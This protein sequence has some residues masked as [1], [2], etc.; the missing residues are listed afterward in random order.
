MGWRVEFDRN[1]TGT[2]LPAVARHDPDVCEQ[3][4]FLELSAYSVAAL[5]TPCPVSFQTLHQLL[6]ATDQIIGGFDQVVVTGD[7]LTVSNYIL[8]PGGPGL[9]YASS[10]TQVV[11]VSSTRYFRRWGPAQRRSPP[12]I[13]GFPPATS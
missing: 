10:D 11:T 12:C 5:I 3:H 6:T 9:T 13:P 8:A 1:R 7:S 4:D 2:L